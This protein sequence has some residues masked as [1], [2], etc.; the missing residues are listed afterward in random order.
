MICLN[1]IQPPNLVI[2]MNSSEDSLWLARIH[3]ASFLEISVRS[4]LI[5][6]DIK[7]QLGQSSV[8][9]LLNLHRLILSDNLQV[10]Q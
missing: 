3:A 7:P 6:I 2:R 9:L 4:V 10:T 8:L 1:Y 5:L